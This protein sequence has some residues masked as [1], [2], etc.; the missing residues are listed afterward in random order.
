MRIF[1]VHGGDLDEFGAP[2]EAL[3]TTACLWIGIA[4]GEFQVQRR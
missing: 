3:P 4:R 1:H 2:P